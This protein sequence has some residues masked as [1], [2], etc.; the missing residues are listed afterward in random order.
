M[1]I[2]NLNLQRESPVMTEP[3]LIMMDD[4]AR[5]LKKQDILSLEGKIN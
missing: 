4:L 1:E 2:K 3:E 5:V